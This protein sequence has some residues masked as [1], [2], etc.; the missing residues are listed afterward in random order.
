MHLNPITKSNF[1]KWHKSDNLQVVNGLLIETDKLLGLL[2]DTSVD[3]QA[4]G[5]K[6]TRY[7]IDGSDKAVYLVSNGVAEFIIVICEPVS[8][9][10]INY[11]KETGKKHHTIYTIKP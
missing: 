6:T 9:Y 8:D 1:I 2:S 5:T 10:S 11:F 4:L 3:W 7:Q